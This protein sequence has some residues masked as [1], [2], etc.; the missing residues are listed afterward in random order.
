MG[1]N[2]SEN[3]QEWASMDWAMGGGQRAEE[4]SRAARTIGGRGRGRKAERQR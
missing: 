3:G 1:E 2:S 4:E